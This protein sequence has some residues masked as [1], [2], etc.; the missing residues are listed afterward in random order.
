MADQEQSS[1]KVW[2][3]GFSPTFRNWF[4]AGLGKELGIETEAFKT[5]EDVLVSL[6]R[7]LEKNQPPAL[8]ILPLRLP[9][10]NG[11]N[12]AIA[13]RAFELGYNQ[14]GHIPIVFLFNPPDS[15][16]FRKVVKFCQPLQVVT[17]GEGEDALKAAARDL[18]SEAVGG[19]GFL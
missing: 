4:G 2:A 18:V 19:K 13:A 17:P 12:V 1:G 3:A 9:I 15:G 14:R 8:L 11:I 16:S 10:V 5:G 7:A 6:T